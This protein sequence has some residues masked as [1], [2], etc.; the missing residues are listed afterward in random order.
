MSD[1]T[2]SGFEKIFSQLTNPWDWAAAAAGAAVGL[3][4]TATA[5]GLDGGTS[6]ASGASAGIALRKAVFA[7][8]QRTF[9][10]RKAIGFID[11]IEDRIEQVSLRIRARS[12]P[13]EMRTPVQRA[14]IEHAPPDAEAND[15]QLL[16]NLSELRDRVKLE[17]DL[18]VRDRT[19]KANE[20]LIRRLGELEEELRA[21]FKAPVPKI[22]KPRPR[23]ATP[24]PG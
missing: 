19:P 14:A 12:I 2:A 5:H 11:V 23:R 17:V 3:G 8:L 6:V 9:L 16:K 4:V 24:P 1:P 20:Q 13:D 21:L 10:K 18:W 15:P 7:S 22:Q